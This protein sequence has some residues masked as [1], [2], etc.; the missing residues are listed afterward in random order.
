MLVIEKK[1]DIRML[2]AMGATASLVKKI[3]LF[4]GALVAFTGAIVGLVMG[5]IICWLQQTYGFVSMGMISSLVDAYPVKM[6]W[7]DFVITAF[8]VI[9]VTMIVSYVP[10]KRASLSPIR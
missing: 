10:A 3:F 5:V 6:Q 7:Q 4:E 2:F 9:L 8:T 1:D